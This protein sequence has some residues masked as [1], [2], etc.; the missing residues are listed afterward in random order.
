MSDS[1]D[2]AAD[3]VIQREHAVRLAAAERRLQLDD[4]VA[5]LAGHAADAV[6]HRVSSPR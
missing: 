6:G 3:Q 2:L 5:A 1:F 4:R